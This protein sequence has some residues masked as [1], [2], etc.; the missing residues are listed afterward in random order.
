[1]T[2]E[3]LLKLSDGVILQE[4]IETVTDAE[5][6]NLDFKHNSHLYLDKVDNNWVAYEKKSPLFIVQN[7]RSINGDPWNRPSDEIYHYHGRSFLIS[8]FH[9]GIPASI[10]EI[11]GD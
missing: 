6:D 2:I 4:D 8:F 9:S 1:M 10:F 5:I 3:T 11:A 7:S